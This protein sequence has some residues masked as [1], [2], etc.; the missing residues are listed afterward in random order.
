[1]P[2]FARRVQGST[3]RCYGPPEILR[4]FSMPLLV[5]DLHSQCAGRDERNILSLWIMGNGAGLCRESRS[6]CGTST[7]P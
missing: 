6:F 4:V 3:K 2:G 1:M 5:S 7:T